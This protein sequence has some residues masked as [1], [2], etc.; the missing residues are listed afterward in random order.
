MSAGNVLPIATTAEQY[1]VSLKLEQAS[2]PYPSRHRPEVSFIDLEMEIFRCIVGTF[3]IE[4]SR[5]CLKGIGES[6]ALSCTRPA[7]EIAKPEYRPRWIAPAPGCVFWCRRQCITGRWNARGN[8]MMERSTPKRIR[9]PA[10]EYT[11]AL[12]DTRRALFIT[13]NFMHSTKKMFNQDSQRNIANLQVFWNANRWKR[14]GYVSYLKMTNSPL[15]ELATEKNSA[16]A[17]H[18]VQKN[19]MLRTLHFAKQR[20]IVES[21]AEESPARPRNSARSDRG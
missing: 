10:T 19:E 8:W 6:L 5:I 12:N 15:K 4:W 13:R 2:I 20:E 9:H 1:L 14:T 16:M 17:L 3:G 11:N 18:L 21:Y 7:G